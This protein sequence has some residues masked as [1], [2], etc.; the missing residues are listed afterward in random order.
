MASPISSR[1]YG[2][3]PGGQTVEAW[4]LAGRGGLLLEVITLGGIV[5]RLLAPGRDGILADVVLGL[6]DLDS[7]LAGH[8]CFGAIAG[9]VAGRITGAAFPLDGEHYRLAPN[10][11]P[12]HL[13]GGVTGF[14]K[15]IWKA[16]PVDR[17]DG[18]PSVRLTYRSPDG[19]EG[20]PG[21]VEVAVTYSVTD[22][23]VFLIETEAAADRTTPLSLTHHSY[24]NLSGE[25]FGTIEDHLLAIDSGTFVPVNPDLTLSGRLEATSRPGNDFRQAQR[26]G[27]AIPLLFRQHG[28]LYALPEPAGNA[29]RIA[30][31]LQDPVSGRGMTVSTTERYLQFYTGCHLSGSHLGKSGTAYSRFAGLCLECEGYADISNP[32]MREPSLL[33]PGETR[34][35]TTAYAFTYHCSQDQSQA[36]GR[37]G[38]SNPAATE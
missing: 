26:L 18:A 11:P 13:H 19:E 28:D 30:A 27:D 16:A 34:R 38:T 36:A 31:R 22:D 8:P 10:D 37:P 23:N 12:N 32:A 33:R 4:T 29:P 14:D 25:S 9:R 15:R 35:N 21:N 20:Y 6:S 17:A 24:F 3:L 1:S 5:T 2:S 7:Y